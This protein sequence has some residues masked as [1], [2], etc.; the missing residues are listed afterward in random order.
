[1]FGKYKS[2][3]GTITFAV[4]DGYLIHMTIDD[5]DVEVESDP[6]MN[7]ICD[8]LH[9]YFHGQ[10]TQFSIPIRFKHGTPF[11]RDVWQALLHIPFGT[12]KSYQTIAQEINRPKAL[13][14]VGQAC[15]KNPIGIIVPCHRVIGKD[16]SMTGYS[17]KAYVDLKHQILDHE[18]RKS[19]EQLT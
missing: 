17:G 11:Q 14:A 15:K 3:L 9:G 7:T 8:E 2:P 13:R 4:E 12:T 5:Q 6:I 16:G 19:S 10:L 18:M 1:M